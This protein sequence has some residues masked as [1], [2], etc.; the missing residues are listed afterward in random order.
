M[1]NKKRRKPSKNDAPLKIQFE[2][3]FVAFRKGNM[4]CPYRLNSM[5]AREWQRGFNSA[6][7][8]NLDRLQQQ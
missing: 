1:F 2:Q 5:Q 3:G 7:F 6:Y 4:K 8:H